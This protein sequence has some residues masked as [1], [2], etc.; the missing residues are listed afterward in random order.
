MGLSS[1]GKRNYV[2]EEKVK[3]VLFGD[4]TVELHPKTIA[5]GGSF[6][7]EQVKKGVAH[8]YDSKLIAF[9]YER[10]KGWEFPVMID[11]GASTGSFTMLAKYIEMG[12][13]F[14]FEPLPSTYNVL[15]QNIA[16]NGLQ[17]YVTTYRQAV[18]DAKG[19]TLKVPTNAQSGFSTLGVPTRF[20]GHKELKV[21]VVALDAKMKAGQFGV[22]PVN[23]IKSDA[24]GAD[25]LVMEGARKLIER[26]KPE[27]VFEYNSI[28]AQQFGGME[29]LWKFFGSIGYNTPRKVG[30]EDWWTFAS[31]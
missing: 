28:A 30:R 9:V 29:P 13:I 31:S 7:K 12:H 4:C 2:K 23:L 25:I 8:A 17:R 3:G 5:R 14:A 15:C 6:L 24:N 18:A 26:Y 21:K 20:T 19:R 10:L 16:L 22:V 1:F 11:I 27:I